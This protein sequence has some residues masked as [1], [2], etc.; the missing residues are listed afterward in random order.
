MRQLTTNPA[1][2]RRA[3]LAV[4][5]AG[6]WVF[7]IVVWSPEAAGPR[8]QQLEVADRTLW[9]YSLASAGPL[10]LGAVIVAL[11]NALVARI[12]LGLAALVLFAGLLG[13]R[14]FGTLA[15]GTMLIPGLI[16]LLAIP[17][18]G[19]MPTPEQEGRPRE[20]LGSRRARADRD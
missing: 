1:W 2:R 13:F 12:M 15:W 17:F 8:E 4:I 14:A 9:F 18:L 16:M 10:A 19:P 6:F 20:A 11:K 7:I 5:V 3:N